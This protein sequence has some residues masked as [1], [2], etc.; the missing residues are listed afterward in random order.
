MET[1]GLALSYHDL[2][3]F[4]GRVLPRCHAC[5][6][7]VKLLGR[8]GA[9]DKHFLS[10]AQGILLGPGRHQRNPF[11]VQYPSAVPSAQLL[12]Y[13]A[14][15]PVVGVSGGLPEREGGTIFILPRRERKT[16]EPPVSVR[17][18]VPDQLTWSIAE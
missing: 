16:D 6:S 13:R 8:C 4:T 9:R 5:M 12:L 18:M 17:A 7:S 2:R 1:L 14:I 10:F 11:Q 15:G 3:D